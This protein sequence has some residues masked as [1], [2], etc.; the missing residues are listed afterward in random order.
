MPTAST[1]QLLGNYESFEPFTSNIYTRRTLAG[2]FIV[3]NK[4]LINDLSGDRCLVNECKNRVINDNGSIQ[5]LSIPKVIKDNYL[6]SYE[7]KQKYILDGCI[8]RGAYIDQTQSMNLY[9]IQPD[10]KKL[11]SAQ[12]YAWEKGLKQDYII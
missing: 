8:A 9:F 2:E 6:T 11:T 7:I 3:V 12:F 10:S 1:S 5:N 4:H